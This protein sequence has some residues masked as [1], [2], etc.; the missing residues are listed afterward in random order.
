MTKRNKLALKQVQ[1]FANTADFY[2]KKETIPITIDIPMLQPLLLRFAQGPLTLDLDV[3]GP[4][5]LDIHCFYLCSNTG[6]RNPM[7]QTV[8]YF[9]VD[10]RVVSPTRN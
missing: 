6:R 7:G 1:Q 10:Y 9:S 5:I 2:E 3:H 4:T 8:K